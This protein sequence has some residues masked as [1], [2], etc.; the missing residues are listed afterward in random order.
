VIELVVA[1][2]DHKYVPPELDTVAVNTADE[3]EQIVAEL[4]E[5]TGA[6]LKVIVCATIPVAEF[7]QASVIRGGTI[8]RV[9]LSES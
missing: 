7:P 6:V 1:P 2:F 4:I 5:T 9:E 3:P 8:V